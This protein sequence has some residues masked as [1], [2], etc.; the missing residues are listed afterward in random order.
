MESLKDEITCA[1]CFEVY[2][3]PILLPC[4]HVFCKLCID[5]LKGI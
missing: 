3:D 5:R 1:I 2:T 4:Q